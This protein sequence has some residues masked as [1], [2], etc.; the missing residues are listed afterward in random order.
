MISGPKNSDIWK[1]SNHVASALIKSK[2]N[3]NK[4]GVDVRLVSSSG[5]YESI[6]RLFSHDSDVAVVDA[7]SAYDASTGKGLFSDLLRRDILALA[8]LGLEVEHFVLVS[9]KTEKNDI[10]DIAEKM[11]YLGRKG[12]Y[13]RY[14]AFVSL[15]ACG[16][17][18]FFEGGAEW[19]YNTSAELMIDG[20]I[21]GAVYIGIPPIK[22][23]SDLKKIMG[24][25]LIILTIN[26]SKISEIREFIPVWFPHTI[27]A[28]TYTKQD[29]PILTIAKPIL[30]VSTKSLDKKRADSL[31]SSLF[32]EESVGYLDSVGHPVNVEMSRKYKVIKYHPGVREF[33]DGSDR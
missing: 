22:S 10:S 28:K 7:L 18:T 31:V 24:N 30:L 8:V 27:P 4:G 16:I 33:I 5:P 1:L 11:L 14:G 9:S 2:E 23:V 19:D 25:A 20:S 3:S 13:R 6:K 12:D 26:D 32:N 29:V 17:E 15:K 21:D